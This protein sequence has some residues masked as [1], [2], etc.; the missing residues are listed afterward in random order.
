MRQTI[1]GLIIVLAAIIA[2]A[3]AH[4]AGFIVPLPTTDPAPA[5]NRVKFDISYQHIA[6]SITEAAARTTIEQTIVNRTL[7]PVEG[8]YVFPVP[9]GAAVSKFSLFVNDM[10]IA[11]E[12]LDRDKARSIYED[13]VRRAQDPALL[14]LAGKGIFR[15]RIFPIEAGG[16]RKIKLS[17]VSTLPSTGG[18]WHYNC[19]IK[20]PQYSGG[21]TETAITVNLSSKFPLRNIYSPSH[22]IR[23]S[24]SGKNSATISVTEKDNMPSADFDLFF[25]TSREGMGLSLLTYFPRREDGYFMLL[26]S[27]GLREDPDTITPKD[28]VFVFDR[29]GSMSGSKM[30]QARNA[31]VYCLRSLNKN[32]R[33]NVIT[34]NES[35]SPIFNQL[36]IA[37]SSNIREAVEEV[38][39]MQAAGGTN[40]NDALTSAY[41]MLDPQNRRPSYIIF[42]TD[43]LP[44]AGITSIADI[45][46]NV[47]KAAR[48]VNARIFTFGVGY[49]VN[50]L[51]LD[52]LTERVGGY[53]AY[54]RP[55]EDIEVKVSDLFRMVNNPVLTGPEIDFGGL[56][57]YDITPA[58]YPDIYSG[59]NL[60]ITG[61]LKHNIP[62]TIIIEGAETGHQRKYLYTYAPEDSS[63]QSDFI[64]T[65]W[66]ARRIGTLIKEI[67]INGSN[68]E[69]VEEIVRLSKRYGIVTEYTSFLAREDVRIDTYSIQQMTASADRTMNE[70]QKEKSGKASVSRSIANNAMQ[71][72]D[73]TAAIG[74]GYGASPDSAQPSSAPVKPDAHPVPASLV[75]AG[76]R[77]FKHADNRWIDTNVDASTRIIEIKSFS[78]AMLE[79]I[80]KLPELRECAAIGDDVTILVI[81]GYAVRFHGAGA[82]KLNGEISDSLQLK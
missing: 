59:T 39:D 29:T 27:P 65:I 64:P 22:I 51:L 74:K 12:I 42:L 43:G 79:L 13:I 26:A 40:I 68:T 5:P 38:S 73:N 69:L 16:S 34:F 67:Q 33:F 23:T 8:W 28:I 76:A 19:P 71:M 56:A 53:G 21:V 44:T 37:S 9:E 77:A 48:K 3:G 58:K 52:T 2:P 17:Y 4:A 72:A 57:P 15:A 66:A 60:I 46:S 20:S 11:G 47:T 25:D 6:V 45:I 62:S 31:L 61:R 24:R 7:R 82:T 36:R 70:A 78:D 41:K 50:T 32:D 1:I 10:E 35:P 63:G 49:D 81:P 80:T 18:A 30:E 14:E 75:M 54:V 55:E